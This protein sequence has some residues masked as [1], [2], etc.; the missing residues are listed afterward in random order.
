MENKALKQLKKAYNKRISKLSKELQ[1][2]KDVTL[3]L[4]H[5][6]LKL[7]RDAL[8]IQATE[9]TDELEKALIETNMY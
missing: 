7:L 1:K 6:R 2:G 4:L 5:E 3:K 9:Q 8:I